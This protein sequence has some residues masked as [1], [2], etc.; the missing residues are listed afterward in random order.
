MINNS[1][2]KCIPKWFSIHCQGISQTMIA[3]LK[4]MAPFY[5]R[6]NLGSPI[7]NKMHRGPSS[8][9]IPSIL[10]YG[11][12][13]RVVCYF[14]TRARNTPKWP[15]TLK[16]QRYPICVSQ[17]SW[18]PNFTPCLLCGQSSLVTKLSKIW[19]AASDHG[20][21]LNCQKH[22][23]Y[24]KYLPLCL[25][26]LCFV[27]WPAI[28]EIHGCQKFQ[29]HRTTSGWPWKIHCQSTPYMLNNYPSDLNVCPFQ[30]KI[31]LVWT[32][33]C[34]K[35]HTNTPNDTQDTLNPCPEA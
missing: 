33:V 22:P 24:S 13:F 20:L 4:K 21:T 11:E 30:P 6:T 31:G 29:I 23:V 8:P 15:W 25:N 17:V 5:R 16:G 9:E 26:L 35:L 10:L 12:P 19:N 7:S 3:I 2:K 1:K 34:G 32:Q 14:E 27:V 18:V 28:F